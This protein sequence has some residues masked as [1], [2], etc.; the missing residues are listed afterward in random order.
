MPFR[1]WRRPERRNFPR[2]FWKPLPVTWRFCWMPP[3]FHRKT[4][5]RGAALPAGRRACAFP[6]G[7]PGSR[8]PRSG[9]KEKAVP[10][11]WRN[12]TGRMDAACLPAAAPFSGVTGLSARWRI[13]TRSGWRICRATKFSA[14]WQSRTQPLFCGGCPPTTACCTATA[15]RENL[16]PSKRC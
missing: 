15:A 11:G 14:G 10:A 7:K 13:P 2:R 1:V 3:P 6:G 9:E 12:I 4:S 5:F 16:R 8:S